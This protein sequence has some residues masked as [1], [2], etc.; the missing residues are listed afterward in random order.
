ML[1]PPP[2]DH[3]AMKPQ[4][5]ARRPLVRGIPHGHGPADFARAP[6]RVSLC[7]AVQ[8]S[9]EQLQRRSLQK[10]GEKKWAGVDYY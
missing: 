2:A 9:A 4:Q 8:L 10:R 3:R 5:R 7:M 6:F 1:H